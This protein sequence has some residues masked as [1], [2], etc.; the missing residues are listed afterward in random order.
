MSHRQ[1]TNV[2]SLR[3]F[4]S[5]RG[6]ARS[7]GIAGHRQGGRTM[8]KHGWQS[9]RCWYLRLRLRRCLAELAPAQAEIVYEKLAELLHLIAAGGDKNLITARQAELA[10]LY[11][12]FQAR[13]LHPDRH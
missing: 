7:I 2:L 1:I 8:I 10:E 3:A 5:L 4:D 13:S 12:R 9:L 6:L 11:R